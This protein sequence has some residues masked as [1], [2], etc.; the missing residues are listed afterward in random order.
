[1]HMLV[2]YLTVFRRALASVQAAMGVAPAPVEAATDVEM[3]EAAPQ[4]QSGPL[5]AD[6]EAEVA[7]T[8]KT[9]A[10]SKK[11]KVVVLICPL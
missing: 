9:Y 4:E 5:P 11:K 10:I 7:E 3:G 6:I 1:M 2:G 8:Q